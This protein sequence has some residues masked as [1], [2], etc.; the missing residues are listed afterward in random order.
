MLNRQAAGRRP[1]SEQ[2]YLAAVWARL[3]RDRMAILSIVVLALIAVLS[4]LAPWLSAHLLGHEPTVI[5]LDH[6]FAP[7]GSRHWLGTDEYGRDVL[8]RA[9]HAGRI[10]LGIGLTVASISMTIGV[11]TGLISGFYGGWIDD[12]TNAIIQTLL[13]IPILFLLILLSLLMRPEPPWLAFIIGI[14]GWMGTARLVRGEV[15]SIRERDY[16][17]AARAVG[18]TNRRIILRHVLP[19]VSSLIIVIAAFDVAG[20]IMVESGLS[21]L[22]VGVQPPDASWGS[23]LLHSRTYVTKAPWLVITPGFFIFVTILSI[24]L[25]ADGLRDALDPWLKG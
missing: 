7:P 17:E 8:A 10:S 1:R 6:N 24:F 11:F 25:L 13:N 20:G 5:D 21:F 19:N 23:M 9:L 3:R 14:T 15:F 22:G 12:V 16:I 18:A 4:L 2:S